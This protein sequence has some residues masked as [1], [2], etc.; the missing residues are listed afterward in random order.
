MW[1]PQALQSWKQHTF[2]QESLQL[3]YVLKMI[4]FRHT[5]RVGSSRSLQR[6]GTVSFKFLMWLINSLNIW[7]LAGGIKGWSG[8]GGSGLGS[9]KAAAVFNYWLKGREIEKLQNQRMLPLLNPTRVCLFHPPAPEHL[10]KVTLHQK[11]RKGTFWEVG[12]L[13]FKWPSLL[14]LIKEHGARIS[15]ANLV[16]KILPNS[17][18]SWSCCV[19][20]CICHPFSEPLGLASIQ[21][22]DSVRGCVWIF[23]SF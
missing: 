16:F 11:Q 12:K 18:C 20:I 21:N 3:A 17:N 22:N 19:N 13:E 15:T 10:G 4:L 1:E 14:S 5:K 2:R 9:R 8:W 23:Y 7:M 6:L